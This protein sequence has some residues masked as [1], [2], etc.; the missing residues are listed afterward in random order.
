LYNQLTT[1][2]VVIEK[3]TVSNPPDKPETNKPEQTE[4]DDNF[5]IPKFEDVMK[6]SETYNLTLMT[7]F[8]KILMAIVPDN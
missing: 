1:E 2:A 8:R 7:P 6:Y 4:E 3:P 5:E